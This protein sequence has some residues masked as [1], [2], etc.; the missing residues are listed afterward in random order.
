MQ[1]T[2]ILGAVFLEQQEEHGFS[3]YR[4]VFYAD[5]S[6]Q[7]LPKPGW[8]CSLTSW[9]LRFLSYKMG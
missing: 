4:Q 6:A 3:S 8:L 5:I 9:C 2:G 1:K 7:L